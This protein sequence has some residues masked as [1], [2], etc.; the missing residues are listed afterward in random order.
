MRKLSRKHRWLLLSSGA[1]MAASFA[2]QTLLKKGWNAA[3]GEDPP[4]NPASAKF[5]WPEALTWTLAA[6]VVAGVSQLVARRSV[7]T[8]LDGPVPTDTYD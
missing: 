6:S 3:T 1:A 8:V 7:A 4:L 2:T 5:T